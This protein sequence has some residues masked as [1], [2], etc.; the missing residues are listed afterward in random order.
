MTF[1][2]RRGHWRTNSAGNTY[3]VEEHYV[4]LIERF[5]WERV[6]RAPALAY[7]ADRALLRNYGAYGRPIARFLKPNALCPVCGEQVFYYQNEHGS[8][9]FFDDLWPDWPKHPCTDS[10]A[11]GGADHKPRVAFSTRPLMRERKEQLA[12]LEAARSLGDATELPHG[13]GVYS[14]RKRIRIG[15]FDLVIADDMSGAR[16][17]FFRA[18]APRHLL[19]ANRV[20]GIRRSRLSVFD[21]QA[22]A[23]AEIAIQRF[24]SAK[25]F[26]DILA[27]RET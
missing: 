16:T 19:A 1:F 17:V 21:D 14:I 26:I 24:R 3:W 7:N 15:R 9:V 10:S 27:P 4:Q 11:R 5:E 13:W 6:A 2:L 20:I 12:I 18:K 23:A 22:M 25:A 8:R